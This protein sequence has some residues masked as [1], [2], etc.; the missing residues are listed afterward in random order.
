VG[1]ALGVWLVTIASG[2]GGRIFGVWLVGVG[3]NNV[4]RAIHAIDLSRQTNSAPNSR[5]RHEH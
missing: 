4:P 1:L 3:L 5:G 2:L